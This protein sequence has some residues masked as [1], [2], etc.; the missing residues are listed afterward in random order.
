MVMW[1][2]A[3]SAASWPAGATAA[4]RAPAMAPARPV[5]GARTPERVA[6]PVMAKVILVVFMLLLV[7]RCVRRRGYGSGRRRSSEVGGQVGQDGGVSQRGGDLRE[8]LAYA[9]RVAGD[10]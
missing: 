3:S 1:P 2:C 5:S 4:A 6:R 7:V 10:P 9:A 8:T